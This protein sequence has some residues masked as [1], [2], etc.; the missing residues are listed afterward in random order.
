M[1]KFLS[2]SSL[3]GRICVKRFLSSFILLFIIGA[4]LFFGAVG[5][6]LLLAGIIL[7]A[8]AEWCSLTRVT[9][10]KRATRF[11]I[12]SLFLAMI[13][14][15]FGYVYAGFAWLFLACAV[16]MFMSWLTWRRGFFWMGLGLLY[17]GLP[18]GACLA[19]ITT[20]D[21]YIYIL[22]WGVLVVIANDVGGYVFGKFIGGYKLA[23]TI[24]PKKTWAGVFGGLFFVMGGSWFYFTLNGFD[25]PLYLFLITSG[26]LGIISTLGDLFESGIKRYH[27]MKDSGALIPGHGG[28]LD[29]LDGFFATFPFL[30]F[31]VFLEPK[32]FMNTI[33]DATGVSVFL[34]NEGILN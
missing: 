33:P 13:Q 31:L 12:F 21:K 8:S 6:E 20:F 26:L 30:A 18:V 29:R 24:S 16:S 5:L 19:L 17:I 7:M 14:I 25:M 10:K 4:A 15:Y 2:N 1:G 34:E 22:I 28:L 32:F 23:P 3:I 27:G 9:Q 11:M